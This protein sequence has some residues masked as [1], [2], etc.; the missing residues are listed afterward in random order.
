MAAWVVTSAGLTIPVSDD[1]VGAIC[2]RG[3]ADFAKLGQ[4]LSSTAQI[5]F[6]GSTEFTLA[7]TRWSN[8]DTPTV[9][10]V[11]VAGTANDVSLTVCLF[12][13]VGFCNRGVVLILIALDQICEQE[14]YTIPRIQWRT[15]CD[16]DAWEDD[17][18]HRHRSQPTER[19]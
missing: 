3:D 2:P 11:V 12:Y 14:E 18:W 5:F 10:V 4:Q 13:S 6:P 19:C 7:T 1:G 16:H 17:P 9:N 8:L 15:R